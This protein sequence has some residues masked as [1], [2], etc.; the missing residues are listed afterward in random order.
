MYQI[1]S[2]K[3]EVPCTH[4]SLQNCGSSVQNLLH[5][6]RLRLKYGVIDFIKICGH[7]PYSYELCHSHK[8]FTHTLDKYCLIQCAQTWPSVDARCVQIV[9]APSWFLLSYLPS[10]IHYSSVSQTFFKWGP[11][12]LVR[13]FYGPPYS[14]DYQTH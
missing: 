12:S 7:L 8:Y 10:Q 3:Q 4:I 1:T 2:S 13:M 5:V 9:P 11:L 14:W 6:N